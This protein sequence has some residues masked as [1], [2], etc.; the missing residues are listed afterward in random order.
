MGKENIKRN[1]KQKTTAK[2]AGAKKSP[3]NKKDSNSF[4]I[5]DLDR[6]LENDTPDNSTRS[7]KL[8]LLLQYFVEYKNQALKKLRQMREERLTVM[9]IPHNE[10]QIKNYHI[11][12]L[13]LNIILLVSGIV[14]MISAILIIRHNSTVQEVDKLKISQKDAQVQFAKVRQEIRDIGV[15]YAKFRRH[16]SE[17]SGL[18]KGK[19]KAD[20]SLFA[21]GGAEELV[22][23]Q[24]KMT[25]REHVNDAQNAE[26]LPLEM[27]LLNRIMYEMKVAQMPMDNLKAYLKKREKIIRNSP[28]LWP[29]KGY[30]LNPY[31]YIRTG[32]RLRAVFNRGI[33]IVTM[34]GAEVAA[35]APGVVVAIERDTRFV[36]TVR[37]RHNY[38]FETVYEGLERV[39]VGKNE[40]LSKGERIGY[41]GNFSDSPEHLL[42]YEI[43]IGVESVDPMPYISVLKQ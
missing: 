2:K 23:K 17:L 33:D 26:E 21:I 41:V 32:D 35:T 4:A 25:F 34:P 30:I 5:I 24:E 28:T 6:E 20:D 3:R 18:M 7:N 14:I 1:S 19:R 29:T 38:G 27:F 37:I 11:S 16:I 15:S 43:H 31:G 12:N 36:Y 40:K 39:S 22:N 9:F 8:S 42:H 13:S 10:N